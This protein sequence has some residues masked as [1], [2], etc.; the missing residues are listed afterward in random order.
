MS[1]IVKNALVVLEVEELG[2]AV[3]GIIWVNK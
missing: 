1:K 2:Q 3:E